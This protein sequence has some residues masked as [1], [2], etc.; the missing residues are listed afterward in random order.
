MCMMTTSAPLVAQSVAVGVELQPSSTR[1]PPTGHLL[2]VPRPSTNSSALGNTESSPGNTSVFVSI[3]D[4]V[5]LGRWSRGCGAP[6]ED[7]WMWQSRL[8]NQ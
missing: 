2:T 7:R 3:W 4:Q 1:S 6:R 8:S 5:S